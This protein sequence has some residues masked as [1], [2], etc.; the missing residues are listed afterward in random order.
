MIKR[1]L[2]ALLRR[3]K[4][5]YAAK[6]YN[7]QIPVYVPVFKNQLLKGRRALITGGTHGIGLAI[8]KAFLDAGAEV[9]ITGRSQQRIDETI[10]AVGKPLLSGME[11]DCSKY[12]EG[13]L[14][15][16]VEKDGVPDILVNNAGQILTH[17]FPETDVESYDVIMNTNLKGAYFLTQDLV[18][19]WRKEGEKKRRNILNICS[20]S[21]LRPGNSPYVLSKWGMRTLT[22]GWAKTLIREGIVVNGLAPGPTATSL[23][24]GDGKRGINWPKNPTGRLVTEEEIA[25]LAV[26]LVSDMGQMVV[27]DVLYVTGGSGVITVDDL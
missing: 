11:L 23:F 27:G 19:V 12:S 18:R 2:C 25:N 8:A 9:M 13:A 21:S 1:V 26:I 3:M 24:V 15:T 14:K 10:Q 5:L 4:A 17:P 6:T 22:I 7:V 20:S 16:L